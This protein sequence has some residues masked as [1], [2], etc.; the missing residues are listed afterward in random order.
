MM[1]RRLP[2]RSVIK[3]IRDSFTELNK[4]VWPTREQAIQYTLIVLV[5]VVVTT[6]LTASLDFGLSQGL[7]Q[8][9]SWSQ[10]V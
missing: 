9:I 4:V 7:Q 8:I 3:F 5:S 1:A 2:F 10:R 6:A